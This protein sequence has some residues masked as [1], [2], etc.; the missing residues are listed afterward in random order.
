MPGIF[1]RARQS[2]QSTIG[3]V[4]HSGSEIT[5]ISPSGI[6]YE[7]IIG[8]FIDVETES[9]VSII[10]RLNL[11]EG[12]QQ[13]FGKPSICIPIDSLSV[14]PKESE[15][16]IV[17]IPSKGKIFAMQGSPIRDDNIGW[18]TIELTK[19]K[20]EPTPIPEPEPEPESEPET[21]V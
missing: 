19:L 16:W 11:Q 14:V 13:I 2:L 7:N 8:L 18:I 10:N 6:K 21:G 12:E 4:A 1:D 5:L 17:K 20:D 9:N 15:I 3:R